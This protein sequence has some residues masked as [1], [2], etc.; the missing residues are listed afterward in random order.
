MTALIGRIE[1]GMFDLLQTK[2]SGP[3]SDSF[4]RSRGTTDRSA[5]ATAI[6]ASNDSP[7]VPIFLATGLNFPDALPATSA[8]CSS[9]SPGTRS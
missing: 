7:G 9:S 3:D 2:T 4:Y 8:A 5:T 6:G 1:A